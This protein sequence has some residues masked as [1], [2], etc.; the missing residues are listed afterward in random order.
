MPGKKGVLPKQCFNGQGQS[1]DLCGR[2]FDTCRRSFTFVGGALTF[3]G[4]A[5]TCGG[6]APAFTIRTRLESWQCYAIIGVTAG[7]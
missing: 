1:F 5:L 7:A 3:V 4:G 6:G 2:S